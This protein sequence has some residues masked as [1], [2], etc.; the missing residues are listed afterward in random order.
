MVESL[1]ERIGDGAGFPRS[2]SLDKPLK[3]K[4][5][6]LANLH[7]AFRMPLQAQNKVTRLRALNRLDDSILGA[8]SRHAQPVSHNPDCLVMAGVDW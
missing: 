2:R 4:A 3:E 1:P 7:T 5:T 8:A 6:G